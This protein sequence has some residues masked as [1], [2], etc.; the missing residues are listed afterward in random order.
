MKRF[1]YNHLA[2]TYMIDER[3]T[4]QDCD[5]SRLAN[6]LRYIARTEKCS[7]KRAAE[8]LRLRVGHKLEEYMDGA[9]RP[10]PLVD[11]PPYVDCACCG[12]TR[13]QHEDLCCKPVDC[14]DNFVEW[15]S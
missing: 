11:A 15:A 3:V 14:C 8:I 9:L 7:P 6:D 10:M 4:M 13:E 12:Y 2:A 1:T 5:I